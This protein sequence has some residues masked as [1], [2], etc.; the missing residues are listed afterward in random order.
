MS[1][2]LAQY[3]FLSWLRRGVSTRIE[4]RDGDGGP[5][6]RATISVHLGFNA[7]SKS[8]DVPLELLGSG[9][10]GADSFLPQNHQSRDGL[11][12]G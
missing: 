3:G 9:Q 5:A 6:P 12:A 11:Q 7:D 10:E 8:V 4:R 2:P 1:E